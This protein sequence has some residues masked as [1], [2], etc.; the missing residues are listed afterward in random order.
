MEKINWTDFSDEE[1]AQRLWAIR[2]QEVREKEKA[3]QHFLHQ[4]S[5]DFILT[6]LQR[7]QGEKEREQRQKTAEENEITIWLIIAI[8]ICT[9]IFL[10]T[11]LCINAY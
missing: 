3:K 1:L 10:G 11:F 2:R 5:G 4:Q 7:R 9:F 8:I 6:E